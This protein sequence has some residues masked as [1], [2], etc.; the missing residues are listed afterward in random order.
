MLRSVLLKQYACHA[1][2]ALAAAVTVTLDLPAGCGAPCAGAALA[3]RHAIT[4]FNGAGGETSHRHRAHGPQR[5]AGQVGCAPPV[6]REAP[7]A[8]HLVVGMPANERMDW[9][10][11]KATELGVASIQPVV[12]ERSVLR[13]KGERAEKKRAHWQGIALPLR[14][15]R[16]QPRA[17]GA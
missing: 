8:V 6:E 7:A 2:T 5:C 15:V 11:E 10:V 12:A 4:L 14:A 3:A 16:A 1:F 17:P 13:L 9:L